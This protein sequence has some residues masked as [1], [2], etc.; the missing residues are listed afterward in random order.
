MALGKIKGNSTFKEP[1]LPAT[2]SKDTEY[3]NLIQ[4]AHDK[5]V[6]NSEY[7]TMPLSGKASALPVANQQIVNA[8]LLLKTTG[9]LPRP[10]AAS[11]D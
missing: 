4:T 11:N 10:A 5:P 6:R 2:F 9:R 7:G 3:K 1:L 8:R